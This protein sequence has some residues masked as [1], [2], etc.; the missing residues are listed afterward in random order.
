MKKIL[1]GLCLLVLSFSLF[2]KDIEVPDWVLNCSQGN[3]KLA[4]SEL[5]ID[6]NNN[7][8]FTFTVDKLVTENYDL[9]KM[10]ILEAFQDIEKNIWEMEYTKG[11]SKMFKSPSGFQTQFITNGNL[12]SVLTQVFFVDEIGFIHQYYEGKGNYRVFY[13]ENFDAIL[14]SI[15]K[16]PL[17]QSIKLEAE[18]YVFSY[19]PAS[20]K[21]KTTKTTKDT[22]KKI[23]VE[24]PV[25]V[26]AGTSYVTQ[27]VY[28][29]CTAVLM[30]SIPKATYNQF[31][32]DA[33]DSTK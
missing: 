24:T 11:D 2:A 27:E 12:K 7:K 26:D 14:A 31:I 32:Q 3:T 5:G 4:Y 16:T 13:G 15:K 9:R 23:K 1:F 20:G 25:I 18:Y 19:T 6:Y 21:K 8:I 29:K 28:D 30:F 10:V 17:F 33:I 22:N